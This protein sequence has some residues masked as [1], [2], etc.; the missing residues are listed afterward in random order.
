MTRGRTVPGSEKTELFVRPFVFNSIVISL[1][2]IW[3]EI[4]RKKAN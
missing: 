4:W 2:L 3:R 1:D